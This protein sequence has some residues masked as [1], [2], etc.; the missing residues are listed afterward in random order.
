MKS[1]PIHWFVESPGST[2]QDNSST[3][4]RQQLLKLFTIRFRVFRFRVFIQNDNSWSWWMARHMW[5]NLTRN[6]GAQ[7]SWTTSSS[8]DC[9]R[10]HGWVPN[11][12]NMYDYMKFHRLWISPL[13][14]WLLPSN[15]SDSKE[16][17]RHSGVHICNNLP[18]SIY[19]SNIHIKLIWKY[20][21]QYPTGM[22]NG[23]Y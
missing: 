2:K 18:L 10:T 13:W 4:Q 21:F 22:W 6:Q 15:C 23:T 12:L 7:W 5:C 3:M 16:R 1:L 11:V 9:Y 17:L 14:T 20:V 19:W 8:M